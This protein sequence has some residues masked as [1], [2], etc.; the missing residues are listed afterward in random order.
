MPHGGQIADLRQAANG[1][2]CYFVYGGRAKKKA[3]SDY[4]TRY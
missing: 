4:A 2:C 1:D 3:E